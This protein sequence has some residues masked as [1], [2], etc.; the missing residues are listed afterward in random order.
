[1]PALP[2]FSFFQGIV[3]AGVNDSCVEPA[4]RIDRLRSGAGWPVLL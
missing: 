4:P 2:G 3:T 1:M